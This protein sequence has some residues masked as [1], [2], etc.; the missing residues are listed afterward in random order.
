MNEEFHV[1][2][3]SPFKCRYGKLHRTYLSVGNFS[4]NAKRPDGRVARVLGCYGL[5]MSYHPIAPAVYFPGVTE[6]SNQAG[7]AWTGFGSYFEDNPA[8]QWRLCL[9]LQ[10]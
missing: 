9:A 5:C 8:I 10:G 7:A 6:N 1:L 4:S 2:K 3:L